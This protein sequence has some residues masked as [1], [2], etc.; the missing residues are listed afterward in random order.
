MGLK[1]GNWVVN[2]NVAQSLYDQWLVLGLNSS[3]GSLNQSV[4]IKY[5]NPC[6]SACSPD[7]RFV[8]L[9]SNFV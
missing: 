9:Q 7:N 1:V 8:Y 3:T 4:W 2:T 5:L 6:V